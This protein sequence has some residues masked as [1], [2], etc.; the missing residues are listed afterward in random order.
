[1]SARL[2]FWAAWS[3]LMVGIALLLALG[4]QAHAC[5]VCL[6]GITIT[7]GQRLDSA[8][9]AVLAVP[10]ANEGQFRVIEVIKGH[11]TTDET[12]A[13]PG[14]SATKAEPTMSLDGP[15]LRQEPSSVSSGKPLL[16]VRD[17]LSE[18]W[19]SIGAI[20][21]DHADWLRQF[22]ATNRG[23]KS[24]PTKNWQQIASMG[25]Y[26]TD[27]EWGER[28]AVVAPYLED[29]DALAAEIAYGELSRAP[30]AA[31]RTLEPRLDATKI[32]TWIVD[33]RLAS[34]LPAYTLLIGIAG[35]PDDANALE[36]RIAAAR[37]ARDATN[38]AAML[39]ADIELRGPSRIEWLEQT[40]FADRTRTLPEIEAALLALSVHGQAD[41]SVPRGRVVEAYRQFIR[42]RRPMAGFV[43]MELAD[44]EAWEATAD[45]VEII[46][47][48]GVKDPAGEFA[49]LHYLRQSPATTAEAASLPSTSQPE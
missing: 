26:L 3:R 41:A 10:L 49:I 19:A 15:V 7:P 20:D 33:P 43:A 24:R 48:K 39:A 44:W 12:I 29:T 46:R 47:S 4:S 36:Q 22:V 25:S 21:A 23:G 1:M 34:R 16:L 31:I 28:L 6:S 35:G 30:Y 38:L 32:A 42:V 13:Q 37:S 40:Y 27:A 45:Y 18:E 17:K 14:L 2:P 5:R 8:A 11:A 9:D